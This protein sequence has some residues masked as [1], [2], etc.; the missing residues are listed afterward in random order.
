MKKGKKWFKKWMKWWEVER[1]GTSIKYEFAA[2]IL[3]SRVLAVDRSEKNLFFVE[4]F[5][6]RSHVIVH[7]TWRAPSIG[8]RIRVNRSDWRKVRPDIGFGGGI[9]VRWAMQDIAKP[10]CRNKRR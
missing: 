10:T 7:V 4:L 3:A 5:L 9:R 2:I 8:V 6:P 1:I